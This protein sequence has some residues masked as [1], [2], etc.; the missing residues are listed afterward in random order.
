MINVK[1]Y[2]TFMIITI[3]ISVFLLVFKNRM[4]VFNTELELFDAIYWATVSLTTAGYGDIYAVS[5]AGKII[6]M[7]SSVFGIA[8]EAL[9]ADII[10]AG[11]MEALNK[12][13]W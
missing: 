10:T 6:T 9:P 5:I 8:N 4:G 13:K 1:I 7:I 11:Y 3:Y 12:D 2:E